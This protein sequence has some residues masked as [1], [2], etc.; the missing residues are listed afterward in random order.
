MKNEYYE[1]QYTSTIFPR[2]RAALGEAPKSAAVKTVDN[3]HE[4]GEHI[5]V[6]AASRGQEV[7]EVDE[8]EHRVAFTANQ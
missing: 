8:S 5:E 7:G 2:L 1:F 3:R 6:E 4:Q